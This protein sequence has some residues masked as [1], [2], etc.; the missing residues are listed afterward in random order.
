METVRL[1]CSTFYVILRIRE[2]NGRWIASADPP[3][4]PIAGLRARLVRGRLA[5]LGAV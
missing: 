2:L 5:G 4:R 3:R 1:E